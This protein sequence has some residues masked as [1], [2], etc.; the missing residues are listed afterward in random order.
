M[1]ATPGQQAAQMG[2]DLSTAKLHHD[3]K[4]GLGE[5][6]EGGNKSGEGEEE[7]EEEDGGDDENNSLSSSLNLSIGRIST[8]LTGGDGSGADALEVVDEGSLVID[9]E[10]KHSDY[11][12]MQVDDGVN[13]N[14]DEECEDESLSAYDISASAG[15]SSP[16]T[17]R[18]S[19]RKRSAPRHADFVSSDDANLMAKQM[20]LKLSAPIPSSVPVPPVMRNVPEGFIRFHCSNDCG[21]I[22]CAYRQSVTH[23]HCVRSE[24]GYGFSDKSRIIQHQFR[25]ERLDKLMGNEFQQFRA[26]VRCGRGD[27]E[28]SEKAS[29]FHCQKCAFVC[30]DS[31]KVLAHRK[32]HAKMDNIS[33][34][35]FQKFGSLQD[36]GMTM[37]TYSRKQT[38]YHCTHEGCNHAVLGPAQMAP[39]KLKHASHDV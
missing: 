4:G 13:G 35:G 39:H 22:R 5:G 34:N 6:E 18:R 3:G 30:A 23:Y 15:A 26:T 2:L 11:E 17:S 28:F 38:H 24:C 33:S 8:S 31:S 7:E 12:S 37:C 36:C 10:A 1:V 9:E 21:Y 19:G 16:S 25:H 32:Y 29:H 27:C 14:E 20:K